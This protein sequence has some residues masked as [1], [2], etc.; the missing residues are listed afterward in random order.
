M[1]FTKFLHKQRQRGFWAVRSSDVNICLA[2]QCTKILLVFALD[3]TTIK[4]LDYRFQISNMQDCEYTIEEIV[5]DWKLLCALL[6]GVSILTGCTVD[7]RDAYQNSRISLASEAAI[8]EARRGAEICA[9]HAPEGSK[10]VGS[11][12]SVGFKKS[13]HFT[14]ERTASVQPPSGTK[15]LEYLEK[16]NLG[17]VVNVFSH[18]PDGTD[19]VFLDNFSCSIAVQDMSV[20]Q[21]NLVLQ[22]W[23]DEFDATEDNLFRGVYVQNQIL[24]LQALTDESQVQIYI[25]RSTSHVEGRG[26]AVVLRYQERGRI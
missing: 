19:H 10:A 18:I 7:T 21:A 26:A 11:L 13:S 24:R 15:T 2:A 20:D 3:Q 12:K 8:S 25:L 9:R 23:V 4:V 16:R 17:L 14:T 6:T 22:T 1:T 5:V